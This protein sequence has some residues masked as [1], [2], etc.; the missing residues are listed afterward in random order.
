MNSFFFRFN[1]N[2]EIVHE[3]GS[4]FSKLHIKI[5]EEG[6]SSRPIGR[7]SLKKREI[8]KFASGKPYW[9]HLAPIPKENDIFGQINVDLQYDKEASRL[10]LK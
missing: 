8:M 2:D 10:S 4:N 7:V 6:R 3:I 5:S 9:H 1:V